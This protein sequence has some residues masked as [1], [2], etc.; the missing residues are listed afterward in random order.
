MSPF[1]DRTHARG[2]QIRYVT[3]AYVCVF[4]EEKGVLVP[5]AV[6]RLAVLVKC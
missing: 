6:G 3:R 5:Q 2:A 1:L 4:K